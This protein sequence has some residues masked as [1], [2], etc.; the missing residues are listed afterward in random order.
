MTDAIAAS[1]V[2]RGTG[3]VAAGTAAALTLPGKTAAAQK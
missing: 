3:S 1:E 2:T